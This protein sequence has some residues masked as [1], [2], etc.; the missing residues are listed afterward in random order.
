VRLSEGLEDGGFFGVGDVA[1]DEVVGSRTE[2]VEGSAF[3]T[4]R[5]AGGVGTTIGG[6]VGANGAMVVVAVGKDG[7]AF[8]AAREAEVIFAEVA[9]D[10][11]AALVLGTH[12]QAIGTWHD[13]QSRLLH[14][15]KEL[16]LKRK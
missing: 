8:G 6:V 3:E 9:R 16:R 11:V 7:R 4:F 14:I 12:L 1:V 2:G 5:G 15:V 10:M 13:L